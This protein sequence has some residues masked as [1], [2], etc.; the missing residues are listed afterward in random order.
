MAYT[1]TVW[2]TGDVITAEKLNKAEQGIE[3]ASAQSLKVMITTEGTTSTMDKTFKEI[4]DVLDAGGSVLFMEV[5]EYGGYDIYRTDN[6]GYNESVNYYL[7]VN[8]LLFVAESE[9][10]NPSF[11]EL[12]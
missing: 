2:Q 9:D 1:P 6:Y 12:E 7:T 10:D 8:H 4:A 5:G 11:T 3:A